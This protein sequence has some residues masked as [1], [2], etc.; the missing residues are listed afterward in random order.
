LHRQVAS[1]L[2]KDY[3][4]EI[5]ISPLVGDDDAQLYASYIGILQWAQELG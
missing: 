1:P 3:Q 2:P 5:D 4:P